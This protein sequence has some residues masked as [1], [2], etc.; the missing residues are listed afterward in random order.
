MNA[1][2]LTGPITRLRQATLLPGKIRT[3][4]VLSQIDVIELIGING[5]PIGVSFEPRGEVDANLV[6]RTSTEEADLFSSTD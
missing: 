6:F 4:A 3:I 5:G 1:G 2:L